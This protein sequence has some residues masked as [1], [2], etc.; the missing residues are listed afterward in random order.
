MRDKGATH[1]IDHLK[2][3]KEY[4]LPF[5]HPGNPHSPKKAWWGWLLG[6]GG[7]PVIVANLWINQVSF[8]DELKGF[9]GDYIIYNLNQPTFENEKNEI[10]ILEQQM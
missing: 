10:I 7:G 4:C 6:Q 9:F 2:S 5:S 3:K 1:N 8:Q